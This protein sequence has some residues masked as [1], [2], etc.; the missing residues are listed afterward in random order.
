MLQRLYTDMLQRLYTDLT[1]YSDCSSDCTLTCYSY[2]NS[3]LT[4]TTCSRISP[5]ATAPVTALR[6]EQPCARPT[7]DFD[8]VF[9]DPHGTVSPR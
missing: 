4:L 3:D 6:W 9:I 5:H 1:S 2:R 8:L 7:P